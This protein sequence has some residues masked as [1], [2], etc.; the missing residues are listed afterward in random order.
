MQAKIILIEL[1]FP[2]TIKEIKHFV[3]CGSEQV[4]VK[5][6]YIFSVYLLKRDATFYSSVLK[7]R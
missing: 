4:T 6:K 2:E 5:N 7:T 3:K 1:S